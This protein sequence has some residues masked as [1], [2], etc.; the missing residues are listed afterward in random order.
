LE[1]KKVSII[2]TV[3]NSV[4][5]LSLLVEKLLTLSIGNNFKVSEIILVNDASPNLETWREVLRLC[6]QYPLVKGIHLSRNFGQQAATFCGFEHVSGD[7]I[8]TMDDDLQQNPEYLK[9]FFLLASHDVVIG[10]I[11]NRQTSIADKFTTWL[12]SYFDVIAFGKPRHISLSSFRLFRRNIVDAMLQIKS[13][14][15]FVISNLFYV[16]RDVVNCPFEHAGRIEGKSNYNIF[17]R[18]SLFTHIIIDNSSILI[19]VIRVI[20]ILTFLV[21]IGFIFFLLIRKIYW[22]IPIQGW[23]ST[24]STIVFF[25]SLNLLSISILGEYLSRMFPLLERRPSYLVREKIN[26]L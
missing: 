15:P 21:S 16:T 1:V 9:D 18:I 2:V 17:K 12:K 19:H 8:V 7:Y 24:I 25:G 26:F 13:V 5:T 14:K 22:G 4:S 6:K 23:T 3:Y 11:V 20:A 10:S